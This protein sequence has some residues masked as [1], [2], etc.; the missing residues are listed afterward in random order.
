[1]TSASPAL[2][3]PTAADRREPAAAALSRM[4]RQGGLM[5]AVVLYIFATGAVKGFGFA[6]GLTTLIDLAVL[7]LFT[8]PMVSWLAKFKFFN[9]GHRMSGLD[10]GALGV[11]SINVGTAGGRA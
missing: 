2:H 4:L 9:Q 11:D 7:F 8:K 5:A 10:A 1:M 6:L 3:P